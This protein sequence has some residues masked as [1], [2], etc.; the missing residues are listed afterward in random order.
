M[1]NSLKDFKFIDLIYF[2]FALFIIVA[3]RSSFYILAISV[4]ALLI[5]VSVAKRPIRMLYVMICFIP[6]S[7]TPLLN[8]P[9]YFITGVKYLSSDPSFTI[10]KPLNVLAAIFIAFGVFQYSKSRKI[11]RLVLWFTLIY[12]TIFC[13]SV[14]RTIQNLGTVVSMGLVD[15]STG[16]SIT[17]YLLSF[18][19]KP[20][21]YFAPFVYIIKYCKDT[22]EIKKILNA[23][24][25]SGAIITTMVLI[26]YFNVNYNINTV[27]VA[28]VY[29]KYFGIHRNDIST[30]LLISYP[31]V[32]ANFI[33]NKNIF[34]VFI[35][36][37][38]SL[39]IAFLFSRTAYFTIVI[40][41]IIYL[42]LIGK[43]ILI[44]VISILVIS[45][46]VFGS[47]EV[48]ERAMT[49]ID[50]QDIE[51]I[52]AGRVEYLW[53]PLL[54]EVIRNPKELIFGNGRY[55]MLSSRSARSGS[56]SIYNHP[57][58]MYLELLVDSGLF[59]MILILFLFYKIIKDVRLLVF[60]NNNKE[61][62]DIYYQVLVCII[63]FLISGMTG[64]SFFPTID[65]FFFWIVMG[66][67]ICLGVQAKSNGRLYEK[68][69]DLLCKS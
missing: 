1:V 21:I 30:F 59:G 36:I 47:V 24:V 64:R 19:I 31:I 16:L 68:S 40:S 15:D 29:M 3:L 34:H 39:A 65:N 23:L 26:V 27:S 37:L 9:L 5:F 22:A 69:Q 25:F 46:F 54:N 33:K 12:L 60:K 10:L 20:L 18:L 7:A 53:I 2:L 57:H 14:F 67:F 63:A 55:G 13:I 58:N 35:L 44:P 56:L 49:G 8:D 41:M 32:F 6:F 48:R 4:F 11:P 17:G 43:K 61:I 45:V 50:S 62:E 52:S 38:F 42:F 28:D 51:V 66:V